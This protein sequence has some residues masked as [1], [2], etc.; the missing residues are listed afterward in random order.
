MAQTGISFHTICPLKNKSFSIAPF[1]VD[2]EDPWLLYLSRGAG[3][4]ADGDT[5]ECRGTV[6]RNEGG[7]G[8][9]HTQ[10]SEEMIEEALFTCAAP[11]KRHCKVQLKRMSPV[12][13]RSLNSLVKIATF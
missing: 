6:L 10:A 5:T 3:V 11:F 8:A 2:G 9:V 7:R 13:C 1:G 4:V 12:H